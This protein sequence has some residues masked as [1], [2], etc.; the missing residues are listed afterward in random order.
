MIDE[1]VEHTLQR[2]P[3]WL[4]GA[5]PATLRPAIVARAGPRWT[6]SGRG[7][8][9]LFSPGA[10]R[11]EVVLKVAFEEWD[12]VRFRNEFAALGEVRRI[13][14]GSVRETIPERLELLELP[15]AT[16][17]A[18]RGVGGRRA[19]V[20]SP[21]GWPG[22]LSRRLLGRN[23]RRALAWSR[24]LGLHAGV[25]GAGDEEALVELTERFRRTLIPSGPAVEGVRSFARSLGR[26]RIRWTPAWQHGDFGVQNLLIDR[27]RVH[28]YDWEM[29]APGEPWS[30]TAHLPMKEFMAALLRSRGRLSSAREAILAAFT[31]ASWA[32]RV[33][34]REME[35][36]W[37]HPLPLAWAVVLE[38][39]RRALGFKEE[40]RR[41][42]RAEVVSSLLMDEDL[43]R[44]V[45]WLAPQW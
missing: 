34:R 38:E 10:R 36:V 11:P 17:L 23:L 3:G 32:G 37:E 13:L 30:D 21:M 2:R 4:H 8:V 15:G 1:L 27:G 9:F 6:Q 41:R 45:G 24:D 44:S 20:P 43:R 12:A 31:P 42:D 22:I 26:S 28:V 40:K 16:V 18:I 7:F 39:M 33:L 29:A 25:E 5:D 35:R 19:Y 14:P